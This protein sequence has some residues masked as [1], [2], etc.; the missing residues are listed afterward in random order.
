MMD[1]IIFV[2]P[3]PEYEVAVTE[4]VAEFPEKHINGSYGIKRTEHYAEWLDVINRP[5]RYKDNSASARVINK[6]GGLLEN[7]V[8]E[9]YGNILQRYWIAL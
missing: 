7:E 9:D 8:P 5:R 2:E 4:F 3:A 1:N 6:N